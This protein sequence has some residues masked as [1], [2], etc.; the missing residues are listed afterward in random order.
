MAIEKLQGSL[1]ILG[2][3][4]CCSLSL[5]HGHLLTP[6]HPLGHLLM[7]A[8]HAPW[9]GQVSGVPL[10]RLLDSPISALTNVGLSSSVTNL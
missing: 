8:L 10:P 5:E 2:L 6:A 7:E 3:C 4:L 9:L 1:L